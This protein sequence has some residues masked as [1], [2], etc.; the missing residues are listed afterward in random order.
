MNAN[1]VVRA[2][3]DRKTKEQATKALAEM[4]LSVSDYIRMALV[5]VAHDK[6]VPFQVQVPNTLTAKT[7]RKS[8]RGEDVHTA[9]DADDLFEQLGI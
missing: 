6:A 1:T 2:R 9:R 7:L 8:E 4:G 5:H 3:I